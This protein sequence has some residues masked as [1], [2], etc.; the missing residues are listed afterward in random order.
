MTEKPQIPVDDYY[1]RVINFSEKIDCK[2]HPDP[3]IQ[4]ITLDIAKHAGPYGVS[5]IY[6]CNLEGRYEGFRDMLSKNIYIDNKHD[7]NP[8]EY[9]RILGHEVAH[10]HD[11][12]LIGRK[13]YSNEYAGLLQVVLGAAV[14]PLNSAYGIGC[15][16]GGFL[17]KATSSL[18]TRF[19]E[20]R[21]DYLANKWTGY[22][23]QKPEEASALAYR[24][25]S[26]L[27]GSPTI[28]DRYHIS[29]L[30]PKSQETSYVE[31]IKRELVQ[32]PEL[33]SAAELT[34]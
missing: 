8:R 17:L 30:F 33:Q 22:K 18:Y 24:I 20:H 10:S 21:A 19:V 14:T 27:H 4:A 1:D 28:N 23:Q 16:T 9:A 12:P 34:R 29:K 11:S 6:S 7:S 5:N 26:I 15:M 13:L 32:N 31:R 3:L 25:T 2:Q